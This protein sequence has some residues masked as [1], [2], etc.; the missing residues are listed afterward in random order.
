MRISSGESRKND[1]SGAVVDYMFRAPSTAFNIARR[2]FGR[3]V[4]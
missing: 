1:R 3:M 4:R 2:P